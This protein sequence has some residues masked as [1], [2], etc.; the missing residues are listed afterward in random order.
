MKKNI[1]GKDYRL[2]GSL[3]DF[4]LRMYVHLIN[5]KWGQG[6]KEPG[7]YERQGKEYLYDAIL[8]DEYVQQERM[9]HI[10]AP[11]LPHLAAQRQRNPF[12]IHRHFYHMASSQAA[13]I[14]LFLPILH[15]PQA[16]AILAAIPAAP[17]DFT[18]LATDQLDQGYCLEYW[19]GNFDPQESGKGV[20][21][22]KSTQAGTDSDIAIAYRNRKKELCL[23]LIEHKLLENE[24]TTCGGFKSAGRKDKA[25]H[26]CTRNFSQILADKQTCYYHDKC[27]YTYWHITDRHRSFFPNHG[28]LAECPFQSGTNQLWRN[29]LLGLALEEQGEPFKHVSFSVVHHPENRALDD[30]LTAYQDLI[31]HNPKFSVFTSADVLTAADRCQDRDLAVWGKW[32]RSIY[33]L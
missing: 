21:G 16:S 20:L 1:N 10:Y 28:K 17:K 2:P 14:N 3:T 25:R 6:I 12:R 9:P 30:S 33:K 13:N 7:R 26:D 5:W 15:H 19:G 11:I 23:W 32:Y 24:F 18:S 8:P 22:D 27:G 4:Q 31:D 29:Q